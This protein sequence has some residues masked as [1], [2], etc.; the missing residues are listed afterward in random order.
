[1]EELNI[2][3]KEITDR[4]VINTISNQKDNLISP[5]EFKKFL[6]EIIEKIEL[7]MHIFY[8]KKIKD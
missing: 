6:M 5:K 4:E 1:M 2:N 3:D 7:Q 8:T